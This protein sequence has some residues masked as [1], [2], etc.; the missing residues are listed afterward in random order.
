MAKQHLS[1]LNAPKSWGIKRKEIK[2]VVR[3][4]PGPH[5][6]K[7][8]I[9]LNLLV[10]NLLKYAK[11]TREVKSILNKGEIIID[12]KVRKD[13]KFPLGIMDVL[14]IPKL[15]EYYRIFLD[16]KN[17]FVL[18]KIK[19]EDTNLKPF[20]IID[21]T[22]LKNKK[23]Q[24]NLY[25]GK[26]L[27]TDKDIYKV[28][29]T[30]IIDLNNNNIKSHL[31]LEKGSLIYLIGGKHKG[32]IGNLES[33]EKPKGISGR[34]EIVLDIGKRKIN[35]LKEHAFVINKDLNLI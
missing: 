14:E 4:N 2:W 6:L 31:K 3:P 20:K 10:K 26:N 19:K 27:I 9:P 29:D 5:K 12:K 34:T 23:I 25:G 24:L 17:K 7:E 35:T 32:E 8:C 18:A 30:L 13:H 22:N 1:G 28:G 21:K 11:T 15:N 33:I 16:N